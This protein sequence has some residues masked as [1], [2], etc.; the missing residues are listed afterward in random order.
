[1]SNWEW[2]NI[3][4]KI[5]STIQN[6]DF[7]HPLNNFDTY[8]ISGTGFFIN[9]YQILTC[10]HVVEGAVSINILYNEMN[11]ILCNIK[12]IFPD[13]DLAIIEINDRTLKL[14]S[15]ILEFKII[16]EKTKIINDIPVYAIG[17]PLSSKNIKITK[18]GISGCQDSLIQTDAA[19]NS[20]NS[21]GPLVI[22][23]NN[24]YKIIGVNVSK[25]SGD[26]QNT[27]YAIPIYRFISI[28]KDYS[29]MII[30]RPLLL[31]D[32]QPIIQKEFKQNIFNNMDDTGIKITLLNK[33]YYLSQYL[34]E[35]DII[36]SINN[37]KIDTNGYIKFDFY[38]EKIAV[39]D[40]G[41]WFKSDDIIKIGIF[42]VGTKK[43]INKEIKL[44][45][46]EENLLYYNNIPKGKTYYI[47]NN[48][49]IL[50]IITNQHL[51]KIKELNLSL[52]SIIKIFNRFSLQK[53]LFTVYLCD[54]N[55]NKINKTF[56]KYP[57]G[58]IIIKINDLS[59]NNYTEF[60]KIVNENIITKITTMENEE[61]YI[62]NNIVDE[63]QPKEIKL[64]PN[65]ILKLDTIKPQSGLNM[66]KHNILTHS[67]KS[68]SVINIYLLK[69]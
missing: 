67:N 4:V 11:E 12:Y 46:I 69:N 20:G 1:M 49:L 58:E 44:K 52:N 21:G 48:G 65:K 68:K 42:D 23:E 10:Y 27:G 32:Y 7:N 16:N 13:D 14:D 35:N 8:N 36:V 17:Y 51:K 62:T 59:F 39:S 40:I 5:L 33:N 37:N 26:A 34:N 57:M 19:L 66:N 29:E 9:K 50:S 54:L 60:M 47:E 61:Y 24:I 28:Y 2:D 45:I 63:P 64:E 55:Y 41:L 38:P 18:G 25:Q 3:V 53:D 22:L 56:N 30:R 15:H 31:F 43:I 6:N